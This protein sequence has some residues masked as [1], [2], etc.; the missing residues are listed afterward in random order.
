[1]SADPAEMLQEL[2]DYARKVHA[3]ERDNDKGTMAL[4][5]KMQAV[6]ESGVWVDEWLEQKPAPKRPTNRWDP[7]DRNRF[8]SWVQWKL[9]QDGRRPLERTRNWRLLEAARLCKD[10]ADGTDLAVLPD[11]IEP[12]RPLFWLRKS[13]YEDR[14]PE[15][16][17]IAVKLA[18]DDPTRVTS[19][20]TR[21][22]LAQ[23]KREK[24]GKRLDGTPRKSPAAMSAAAN[25]G[26]KANA[27][28]VR[29]LEEIAALYALTYDERARDEFQGLLN[30]LDR[31]LDEHEAGAAA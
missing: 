7:K 6:F 3:A 27:L 9:E 20:H 28:R 15:V 10:C 1:M 8:I 30:D 5:L 23:W 29:I 14:A 26:G 11:A 18:G 16:W 2:G 22:A 13:R 21:D 17:A 24:F 19:K 12:M 31:F 4:A 25:A